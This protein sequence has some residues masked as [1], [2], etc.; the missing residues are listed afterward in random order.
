MWVKGHACIY[1]CVCVCR[2]VFRVLVCLRTRRQALAV[3]LPA[4]ESITA[5]V[6]LPSVTSA[7]R[8]NK[9]LH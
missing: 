7:R 4:S 3:P 9:Y 1:V 2:Y 8:M 6:L 5:R